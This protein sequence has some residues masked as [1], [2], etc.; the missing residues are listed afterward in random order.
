ME[1]TLKDLRYKEV[2]SV[3]DGTRFGYVG[4]LEVDVDSGQIRALVIPGP[5]RFF[6]LFGHEEDVVIPWEDV[7]RFGQDIIL[8]EKTGRESRT[9][10][11]KLRVW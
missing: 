6:G 3:S 10:R 9:S 7:R 5:A 11:E 1:C 4:D 2:I 8:V